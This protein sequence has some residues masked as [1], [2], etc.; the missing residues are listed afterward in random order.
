M[1]RNESE[2]KVTTVTNGVGQIYPAA[3][4]F[5]EVLQN[6]NRVLLP[7]GLN[8]ADLRAVEPTRGHAGRTA[9]LAPHA[10]R[11]RLPPRVRLVT[12]HRPLWRA[13]PWFARC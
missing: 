11:H 6:A 3:Y 9:Q 1:K 8:L 5:V 12:F 13:S 4:G 2:E 10:D 7:V